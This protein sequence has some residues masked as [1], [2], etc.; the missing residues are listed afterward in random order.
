MYF[1]EKELTNYL[2]DYI[3]KRWKNKDEKILIFS[4]NI[5]DLLL[6]QK[7]DHLISNYDIFYFEKR[8]NEHVHSKV[9]GIQIDKENI[10][11]YTEF[12]KIISELITIYKHKGLFNK[13]FKTYLNFIHFVKTIQN[14][15]IFDILTQIKSFNDFK[16]LIYSLS[17]NSET[18][19]LLGEKNIFDWILFE[20]NFSYPVFFI[21]ISNLLAKEELYLEKKNEITNEM[22]KITYSELENWN[23]IKSIYIYFEKEW[24]KGF[25]DLNILYD[26]NIF[27]EQLWEQI[28]HVFYINQIDTDLKLNQYFLTQYLTLKEFLQ[29]IYETLVINS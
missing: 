12:S 28:K 20:Y 7:D 23:Q 9:I 16:K 10:I 15:M 3:Q 2:I 17:K 1:N 14:D 5:E 11:E 6:N 21:P 13:N 22:K 25:Y 27:I 19:F 24:E 8:K 26:S 18:L 4:K 29:A